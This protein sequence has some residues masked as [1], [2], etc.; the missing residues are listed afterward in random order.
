MNNARTCLSVRPFSQRFTRRLKVYIIIR[1]A[2]LR[3]S[4]FFTNSLSAVFAFTT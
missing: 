2:Y 4:I 3:T 1:C